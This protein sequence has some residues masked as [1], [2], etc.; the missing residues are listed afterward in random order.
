MLA[1]SAAVTAAAILQWTLSVPVAAVL[2]LLTGLLCGTVTGAV[3][4]A[5]RLPSFI[6]S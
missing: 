4:V 6:V 3:S 2:G 5:W 1:L